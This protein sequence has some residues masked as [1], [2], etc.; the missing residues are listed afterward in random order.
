MNALLTLAVTSRLLRLPVGL[1]NKT[2]VLLS[3]VAALAAPGCKSD[4]TAPQQI[5]VEEKS[6]T[7]K[8]CALL[9]RMA[10]HRAA[11]SEGP[12]DSKTLDSLEAEAKA[13]HVERPESDAINNTLHGYDLARSGGGASDQPATCEGLKAG[14]SDSEWRFQGL[15]GA[16][17][18]QGMGGMGPMGGPGAGSPSIRSSIFASSFSVAKV[19]RLREASHLAGLPEPS[20]RLLELVER[21]EWGQIP[22]A[23]AAGADPNAK[24]FDGRNSV[25]LA[26]AYDEI[27]TVMVLVKAGA[28]PNTTGFADSTLLMRA[29]K[30][31]KETPGIGKL[32][33]L[34]LKKG[35]STSTVDSDGKTA[36]DHAVASGHRKKLLRLLKPKQ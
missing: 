36:Y 6:P 31:N 15:V 2:V 28:D 4:E 5:V 8:A 29:C 25:L 16:V 3:I 30:T 27:E 32:I 18:G 14:A 22:E 34:L 9:G 26:L 7:D 33:R 21:E 13:L 23:L 20:R 12:L 1:A 17:T 19:A 24:Y 35:A 10:E 11:L